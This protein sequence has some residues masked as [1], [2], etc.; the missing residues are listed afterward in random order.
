MSL[1]GMEHVELEKNKMVRCWFLLYVTN[2]KERVW[3]RPKQPMYLET[4]S[5]QFLVVEVPWR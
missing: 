3:R 1:E 2:R 4:Y 5:Q